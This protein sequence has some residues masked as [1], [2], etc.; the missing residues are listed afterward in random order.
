MNDL[1]FIQA[2]FFGG[3]KDGDTEMIQGEPSTFEVTRLM[4]PVPRRTVEVTT[5]TGIYDRSRSFK[6][7]D[8]R[9]SF[10]WRGWQ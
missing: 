1:G 7:G 10:V 4:Q 3:P 6:T 8:F 5:E 9:A 2:E